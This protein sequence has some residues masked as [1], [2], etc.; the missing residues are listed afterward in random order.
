[1]KTWNFEKD[2]AAI[3]KIVRSATSKARDNNKEDI[4]Q[5]ALIRIYN[6]IEDYQSKGKEVTEGL[7]YVIAYRSYTRYVKH[8]SININS[9]LFVEFDADFVDEGSSPA[10]YVNLPVVD[11]S[12]EVSEVVESYINN[13]SKFTNSEK[14]LLDYILID[15]M[16][17]SVVDAY[18]AL[19]INKS[20]GSR[21]LKKLRELCA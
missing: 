11:A 15:H 4:Q 5:E 21:A 3:I 9:P 16:G 13:R 2:Y 18:V 17:S 20:N 19:G 8:K 7:I 10:L 6:T 1:M 12:Y 14:L